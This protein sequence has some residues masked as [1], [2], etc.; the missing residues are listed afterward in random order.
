MQNPWSILRNPVMSEK[1]DKAKKSNV[2][3]FIVD[4]TATKPEIKNAVEKVYGVKV[5]AVNTLTIKGKL[6]REKN[7]V[8]YSRRADTKKAFVR[9]KAGNRI[10][11]L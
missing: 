5:D 1:T 4:I 9:L 11:S 10:E 6:K 3:T 2:Y 7:M 8:L